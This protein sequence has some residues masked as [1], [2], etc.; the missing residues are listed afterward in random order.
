MVHHQ[1]VA[2][3]RHKRPPITAITMVCPAGPPDLSACTLTTGAA[4]TGGATYRKIV[5][6]VVVFVVVVVVL[7]VVVVVVL[8]LVLVVIATTEWDTTITACAT[9]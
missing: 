7:V 4:R 8:V 6:V 5:S 9:P 1:I 2:T 3:K